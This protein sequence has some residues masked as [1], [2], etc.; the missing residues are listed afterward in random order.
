MPNIG[1]VAQL[2]IIKGVPKVPTDNN[3]AEV[4][5]DEL[6]LLEVKGFSCDEYLMRMP[7]MKSSAV[8]AD[9]PL[10]DGRTLLSGALD[11]VKEVIR[12][13]LNSPTIIEMAAQLSRLGRMRQDCNDFWNT[14]NQ[15]EPV[16][17]KHQVVGEPGPRYA[18]LYNIE[19]DV[20]SPINPSDPLRTVT[21]NIE[22]EYGWRGLPPGQSPKAWNL[23]SRYNAGHTS[24]PVA[25]TFLISDAVSNTNEFASTR[26]SVNTR[27][28]VDISGSLIPGD[29]PALAYIDLTFAN[30][31]PAG[32]WQVFISRKSVPS[33]ILVTGTNVFT[34]STMLNAIDMTL[35]A[36][37]ALAADTGAPR[38]QG[39]ATHRRI[40]FTPV[41]NNDGLR[42]QVANRRIANHRGRY[43]VFVRARQAAGAANDL[44]MHIVYGNQVVPFSARIELPS[45]NPVLQAGTGNTTTW[46]VSYMGTINLPVTVPTDVQRSNHMGVLYTLDDFYIELWAKRDAGTTATLYIADIILIPYDEPTIEL[47]VPMNLINQDAVLDG[48]GYLMHGKPDYYAASH[49]STSASGSA[50]EARGQPITLLPKTD[51]RLYFFTMATTNISDLINDS[52][53]VKISIVPRWSGLRDV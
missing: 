10:T 50:S 38:G 8:Y 44:S 18:L 13:T 29:L 26:Q 36:N 45:V 33:G 15:I 20:E 48:T 11:N 35:G 42:L 24:L 5:L 31:S 32:N 12:L 2:K 3:S 41:N 43:A 7:G 21:L 27:N 52:V 51:Q 40:E 47:V 4:G 25:Q 46:P 19:V 9:S 28:Y 6:D 22:R 49:G 1:G 14:Y 37:S 53:S 16:Y 17:I 34:Q 39:S 23:G 30:V